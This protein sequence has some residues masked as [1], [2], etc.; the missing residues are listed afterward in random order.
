MET[1]KNAALGIVGL[2]IL[3][4]TFNKKRSATVQGI[5][6]VG[7]L[8]AGYYFWFY[9]DKPTTQTV[10]FSPQGGYGATF[11][12]PLGPVRTTAVYNN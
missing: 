2:I 1:W 6:I 8:G 3:Y 10:H 11:Q 12:D 5:V 4:Y 7:L 9:D